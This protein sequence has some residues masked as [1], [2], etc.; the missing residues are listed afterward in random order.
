MSNYPT[1]KS[2]MLMT[3]LLNKEAC[4]YNLHPMFEN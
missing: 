1:T 4:K 2:H 3:D